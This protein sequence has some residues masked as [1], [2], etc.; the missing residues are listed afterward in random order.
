MK[1][2]EMDENAKIRAIAR[3]STEPETVAMAIAVLRFLLL[4]SLTATVAWLLG[5]AY[6]GESPRAN[7]ALPKGSLCIHRP[8]L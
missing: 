3:T 8:G 5:A 6:F 7:I 4:V 2:T 1:M